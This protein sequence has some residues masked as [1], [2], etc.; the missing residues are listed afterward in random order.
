MAVTVT[1]NITRVTVTDDVINVAVSQDVVNVTLGTW[2]YMVHASRHEAGGDDEVSLEGMAGT[3]VELAAHE[4]DTA[5]PHAVTPAQI[6][7]S[8]NDLTDVV[9]A[10]P[11]QYH[12]LA[13]NDGPEWWEN[14][15]PDE[16]NL[17]DKSSTQ[18]IGGAKTCTSYVYLAERLVHSGDTNTYMRFTT[19]Q[20]D[21]YAGGIRM[22]SCDEGSQDRLV[23]NP[24]SR[25]VDFL[26]KD[27]DATTMYVDANGGYITFYRGFGYGTLRLTGPATLELYHHLVQCDGNFVVTLPAVAM[28]GQ[29]F[30]I[31]NT[32]GGMITVDGAGAQQIDGDLFQNLP[33]NKCIQIVS[34]KAVGCWW[35]IAD[36]R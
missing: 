29:E 8:L 27:D 4:A 11:D 22:L 15:T 20:I 10:G 28:D 5:N 14:R 33:P 19:D 31:K 6:A 3:G 24:D 9:I 1:D 2:T 21:F 16:A 17:V 12:V 23:I 36:N 34:D 18:T 7:A 13:F 26:L 30:I 25:N 32:G 35:I